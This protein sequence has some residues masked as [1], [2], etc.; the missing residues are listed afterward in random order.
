MFE[1]VKNRLSSMQGGSSLPFGSVITTFQQRIAEIVEN[2]RM[3]ANLLFMTTYMAS[4]ARDSESLGFV[5]ERTKNAMLQMMLLRYSTAINS[6]IPDE[7]FLTNEINTV[8][9]TYRN[10]SEQGFEL[11]QKWG[12]AY[13]AML[14]AGTVIAVTIQSIRRWAWKEPWLYPI[15]SFLPSVVP[16]F[17]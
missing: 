16:A 11:L 1:N 3:G 14:L 5:A 2:R 4:L 15:W 10:Q 12:D 6:N 17:S 7:D 13:V 8:K 9:S